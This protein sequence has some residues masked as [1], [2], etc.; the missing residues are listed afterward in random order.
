MLFYSSINKE[1]NID[2]MIR[3]CFYKS[4]IKLKSNKARLLPLFIFLVYYTS[5][6]SLTYAQSSNPKLRIDYKNNLL[7]IFAENADLKNVLLKLEDKTGIDVSFPNSL[8]KQITTRMSGISLSEALPRLLSGVNYAIIHSG[9]R[10]NRTVVSEVFVFKKS[11]R[12][13]ISS[14][15]GVLRGSEKQI[16]NIIRNYERRIESVK[17]NL[18]KVDQNSSQGK[19]Y[20]RRIRS[21]ENTI[22][23]LK[24]KIQ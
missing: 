19:R 2:S 18:S 10:K 12:S 5:I 15:A 14:Q 17:K 11:E 7:T 16:A 24:R 23:K 9:S 13:G 4:R 1:Y 21:Y 8:E 3:K 20:L 6:N 22:E